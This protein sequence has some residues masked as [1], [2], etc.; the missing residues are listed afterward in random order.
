M[1]DST[2]TTTETQPTPITPRVARKML[3]VSAQTLVNWAKLGKL[4][5]YRTPAGRMRYDPRDVDRILRGE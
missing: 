3:G 2:T 4:R 1:D 5:Y